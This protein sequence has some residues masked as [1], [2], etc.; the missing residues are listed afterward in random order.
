MD[1]RKRVLAKML[2]HDP[3]FNGQD[4]YVYHYPS[5]RLDRAFSIDEIADNMRLV[6]STDGV[7]QH[8]EITFVSHS[9]GGIVT[10][11]SSS[12]TKRRLLERS[13]CLLFATPTTGSPYA[14]IAALIS[15]N[16]Q[17]KQLYPMQADS[18]LAPLQSDSLAAGLGLS[19]TAPTKHN[20]STVRS[21]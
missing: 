10:R 13:A 15:H 5:P 8:D 21:S 16:P 6:L 4:I 11:P 3:T 14:K 2:T 1:I 19:P 12:D 9:M 20:L 17:F 7:L 18:Y